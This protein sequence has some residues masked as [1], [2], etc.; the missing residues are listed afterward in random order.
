MR[1]VGG[2]AARLRYECAAGELH[3]PPGRRDHSARRRRAH[4]RIVSQDV[5]DAYREV[6][7][8]PKFVGGDM[9]LLAM[10]PWRGI[11]ILRPVDYVRLPA[12][13]GA[14]ADRTCMTKAA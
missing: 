12:N 10:D 6:I 13:C 9:H 5:E 7:G 11:R 1:F 8:R 3:E 14:Q 4:R 2:G